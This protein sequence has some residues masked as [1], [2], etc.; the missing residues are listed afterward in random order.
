LK[1][2]AT[3]KRI[4]I[5]EILAE[6]PVY[7]SPEDVWRRLRERFEQIGLPTVYRNL[8]DL[9]R[10]GVVIKI[11]HPDRRLYYYFCDHPEE[12]HHHFVCVSCR[13]VE[14]LGFCG[15]GQ[16]EEEV[17]TGLRGRVLSHLLQVYGLCS[18]CAAVGVSL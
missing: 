1:L 9:T 18:D 8:D 7:L 13:K 16:I 15:L 12:H 4:A 2:K 5:M 11:I 10:G 6:K 17:E 14:Y 3:P